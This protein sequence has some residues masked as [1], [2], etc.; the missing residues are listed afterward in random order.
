MSNTRKFAIEYT[1]QHY[2]ISF[3]AMA[4]PCEVLV[5]IPELLDSKSLNNHKITRSRNN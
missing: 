2:K 3:F 4:S 1:S 5:E